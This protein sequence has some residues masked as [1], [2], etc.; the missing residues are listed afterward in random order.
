MH[1]H[2]LIN[3]YSVDILICF[4]SV[5]RFPEIFLGK[6]KQILD[7]LEGIGKEDTGA[8]HTCCIESR[9]EEKRPFFIIFLPFPMF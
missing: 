8:R 6:E 3:L 5:S 4:C 7:M 2:L 9:L 1:H